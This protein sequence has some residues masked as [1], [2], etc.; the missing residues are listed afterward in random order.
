MT[1]PPSELSK[2]SKTV[3]G[4][5]EPRLGTLPLRELT[6]ETSYGYDVIKFAE[7]IGLPLDPWQRVAVIRGGELLPSGLPRFRKV[8][9]I[10]ARQNGKTHLIKI[11]ILFWL[12]VERSGSVLGVSTLR[13]Y[14]KAVLQEVRDLAEDRPYLEKRV[15]SYRTDNNDT[16]LEVR[17]DEGRIYYRIAAM[18]RK[19]GRGKTF[20]RVFLDELRE[21]RDWET[22]K[23][24]G[25]TLNAVFDGQMWIATNQGDESGTVLKSWREAG[26]AGTDAELCL[27]E[28]SAPPGAAPDDPE[29][30]AAANPNA[31]VRLSMASLINDARAAMA[32][33][34]PQVLTGFRT[35]IL[36]Q[37]VPALDPA[38]DPERWEEAYVPGDLEGV[39]GR[40]LVVDVAPD[41]QH[42]TIVAGALLPDGRV[43]LVVVEAFTGS[44]AVAELRKALFVWARRIMPVKVGWFPN[45]PAAVMAADLRERK[46]RGRP[47]PSSVLLEEISGEVAAVCMGFSS[48]VAGGE[49]IHGN[50]PLLNAHVTGAAKKWHGDVWRFERKGEGHCDAAYAAAG[51]DHLARTL[52]T[53]V[54]KP[55]I[56]AVGA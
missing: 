32:D 17:G 19:A 36:C 8:L 3:R 42:A 48:R 13:D 45:G 24:A 1:T 7:L 16:H 56:H 5:V 27:I 30:L 10:V 55:R 35:E 43:R 50:E 37:Y 28:Y 12:F 41:N 38:V 29:A 34:D 49:V 18:G 53:P 26:I 54:G 11:L 44:G 2:S 21:H 14:A 46:D 4:A 33:P 6:P 52:P 23:A 15:M 20:R 25:P 40:V 39:R 9:I 22:I 51:A 47:F 31:G